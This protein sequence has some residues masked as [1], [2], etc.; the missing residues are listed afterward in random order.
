MSRAQRYDAIVVGSGPNGF[1]AAITL[2]QA[3][4]SVL[5]F[6]EKK[7][8]GGGMRSAELTLPGF[9]HDI[10]SAVHPLGV[11]SPFFNSIPLI[12]HGLEWIYP[13]SSLAHPFDDGTVAILERSIGATGRTLGRDRMAYEKLMERLTIDWQLVG[14]DLLAPLH[15]PTHPLAMARF[16]YFA[17]R[18]ARKLADHLFI[19]GHAKGL[20]AGLAGHS[21]MPLDKCLTAAFALTLGILGHV[22]GWPISK[23]GSQSIANALASYFLSLG[24]E[25]VTE[26]E[27]KQLKCLPPTRAV[28]FDTSPRQILKIIGDRFPSWYRRRLE[29]YR[30]GPGV[31]KVDWALNNPIPW[32]NVECLTAGTVHIGGTFGEIA[33]SEREVW[34]GKHSDK[35]FVILVQPSLFDPSRAPKENHTAWAYCHVPNGSTKDM[36]WQIERQIERFAPGFRDCIIGRH[37]LSAAQFERYN[38][39][40]IGGDI[41]G[42]VSDIWQFFARPVA[43]LQPYLTPLEGIYICSASTPP[44]G[45]V[46]GMCGYHAACSVLK[47]KLC[48]TERNK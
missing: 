15:F 34:K 28:I 5:M 6:E 25:V 46:H 23:G 36:V 27:I 26:V 18:S 42:G 2:A 22:A 32:R 45:G 31:F 8:I 1:A 7:T 47:E 48:Y 24:G 13:P 20:F 4:L 21:N 37:T 12:D 30:Y 39:N 33:Q 43:C 35:P 14:A 38:P 29:K 17:I 3:G 10:C 19:D 44:G 16:G 41:T 11:S 9:V 40:N